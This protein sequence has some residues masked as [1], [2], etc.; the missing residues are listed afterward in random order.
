MYFLQVRILSWNEKYANQFQFHLITSMIDKPS[1]NYIP[2]DFATELQG[3]LQ[4]VRLERLRKVPVSRICEITLSPEVVFDNEY[5]LATVQFATY[6][7]F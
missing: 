7:P 4:S 2:S 6:G 1:N 5:V 3:E